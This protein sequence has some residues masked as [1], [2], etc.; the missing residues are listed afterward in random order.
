MITEL[1]RASVLMQT[2]GFNNEVTYSTPLLSEWSTEWM[3]YALEHNI[4]LQDSEAR[5]V[6]FT[7]YIMKN[8]TTA[9][10]NTHAVDGRVTYYGED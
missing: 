5:F 1:Q 4:D 3:F 7:N 8:S 9:H 6:H 2:G 10:L